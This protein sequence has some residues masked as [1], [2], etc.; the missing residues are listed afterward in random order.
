LVTLTNARADDI[1]WQNVDPALGRSAAVTADVHRH[2]F[3]RSDLH[4][5]VDGVV[6]KPALALSR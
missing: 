6:L 4:V 1:D 2:G 5:T 3:P